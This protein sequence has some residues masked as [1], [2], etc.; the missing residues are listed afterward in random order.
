MQIPTSFNGLCIY[1]ADRDELMAFQRRA[2]AAHHKV[3]RLTTSLGIGYVEAAAFTYIEDDQ[4]YDE[5]SQLNDMA[6]F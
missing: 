1:E 6:S 5:P 4:E 2:K 3:F